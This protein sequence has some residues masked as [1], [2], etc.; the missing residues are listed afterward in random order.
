MSTPM[1]PMD[2]TRLGPKGELRTSNGILWGG[3]S[4]RLPDPRVTLCTT[5]VPNLGDHGAKYLA[6]IT[7]ERGVVP[8]G[9]L[10]TL[11]WP[12]SMGHC[13]VGAALLS[14]GDDPHAIDVR[15]D[16]ELGEMDGPR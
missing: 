7:D 9:V 5:G 6:R 10:V 14:T 13:M 16:G 12:G 11:L 15:I 8:Q 1:V 4:L 3:V 2:M